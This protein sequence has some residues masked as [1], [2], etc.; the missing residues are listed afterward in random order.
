MMYCKSLR[1]LSTLMALVLTLTSGMQA[2]ERAPQENRIQSIELIGHDNPVNSVAF[3][4]DGNKIVTACSASHKYAARIWYDIQAP[5]Q[6]RKNALALAL[7][8][9]QNRVGQNSPLY[10]LDQSVFQQI[11]KLTIPNSSFH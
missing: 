11:V 2:M 4:P 5:K 7:G 10:M 9:S 6:R 3:S 8:W 1:S